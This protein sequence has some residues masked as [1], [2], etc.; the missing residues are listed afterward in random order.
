MCEYHIKDRDI[1]HLRVSA[2]PQMAKN[3]CILTTLFSF[4]IGT[5]CPLQGPIQQRK[6][7]CDWP[8]CESS[9]LIRQSCS[10]TGED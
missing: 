2:E 1:C 9:A 6:G 10:G 3:Q 8:P 4:S 5:V 7:S